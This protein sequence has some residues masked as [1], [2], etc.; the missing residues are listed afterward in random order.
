MAVAFDKCTSAIVV[1]NTTISFTHTPVG[2]P[3]AVIFVITQVQ[4]NIGI[5]T[6]TYGG[7]TLGAAI[8]T[9]N[10]GAFN[11]RASIFGL[12]NPASGA[13]TATVVFNGNEW[14]ALYVITVTGSDLTTCFSGA[15]AG[16]TGSSAAP[17]VTDATGASGDLEID[18]VCVA[19]TATMTP[20]AGQTGN[21]VQQTSGLRGHYSSRENGSSSTVMS[22]ASGNARW[23]IVAAA[24]KAAAAAGI[25]I[26]VI[27]AQFRQRRN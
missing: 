11:E 27:E 20:G 9:Q 3:S 13:Q 1:N 19:S 24:V 26:P 10:A 15:G 12:A 6:I 8:V 22:W 5:T 25:A 18:G 21:D 4:E 23:A 7:A 16:A 14:A 17:S 2:T